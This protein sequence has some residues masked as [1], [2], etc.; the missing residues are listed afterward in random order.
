MA[1][2]KV[3]VSVTVYDTIKNDL[4]TIEVDEIIAKEMMHFDNEINYRLKRKKIDCEVSLEYLCEI[5]KEPFDA[6]FETSV[7]NKELVSRLIHILSEGERQIII[8]IYF[9]GYTEYNMSELLGI[10][11][12]T[13]HYKKVKALKKMKEYYEKNSDYFNYSRE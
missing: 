10:P 13:I 1:M 5:K 6:D 9:E 11:Q 2:K 4:V 7:V 12:P 3:T 8:G